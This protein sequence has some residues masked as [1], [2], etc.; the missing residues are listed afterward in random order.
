MPTNHPNANR[1]PRRDARQHPGR[2]PTIRA[3]RR[4]AGTSARVR[5]R[6]NANI[7]T[8]EAATRDRTGRRAAQCTATGAP[9]EWP[10]SAGRSAPARPIASASR[11]ATPSK[12]NGPIP[13]VPPWPGSSGTSTLRPERAS[14]RARPAR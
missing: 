7:P 10:S 5:P 8:G 2:R 13:C 6:S 3:T 14:A 9:S 11:S 12:V 4:A 1:R